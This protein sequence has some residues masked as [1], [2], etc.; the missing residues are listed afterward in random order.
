M[1]HFQVQGIV[2]LLPESQQKWK[3]SYLNKFHFCLHNERGRPGVT[4]S[5]QTKAW[6]KAWTRPPQKKT[7]LSVKN[8]SQAEMLNFMFETKKMFTWSSLIH[9]GGDKKSICQHLSCSINSIGSSCLI[10]LSHLTLCK[11]D[12]VVLMYSFTYTNGLQESR[13]SY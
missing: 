9:C 7:N 5:P 11:D 1:A 4:V 13:A 12:A 6:T 8:L 3:E 10:N 2:L